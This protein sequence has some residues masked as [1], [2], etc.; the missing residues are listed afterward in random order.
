M[1][2]KTV[3]WGGVKYDLH[4]ENGYNILRWQEPFGATKMRKTRRLTVAESTAFEKSPISWLQKNAVIVDSGDRLTALKDEADR[5]ARLDMRTQNIAGHLTTGGLKPTDNQNTAQETN[6]R[7][8]AGTV[9]AREAAIAGA[10]T[11]GILAQPTVV[12]SSAT[13]G[14]GVPGGSDVITLC[15]C[16][17]R[18]A[19][20]TAPGVSV[21]TIAG[22]PCSRRIPP[23]ALVA[24]QAT[25]TPSPCS[26][27]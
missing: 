20:A 25:P 12:A 13:D 19:A 21:I 24:P 26:D 11:R 17:N 8:Q 6:R 4:A 15:R 14:S 7:A 3:S 22:R 2:I 27:R 16:A 18:S 23:P 5:R 10:R 1:L 9:A